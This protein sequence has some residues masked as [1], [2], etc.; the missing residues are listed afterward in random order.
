MRRAAK[1]DNI[2]P[3]TVAALRAVGCT[4]EPIHTIGKGCPDLLVGVRGL[5]LL[6][7]LKSGNEPLTEAEREWH[8]LWRGQRIVVRSVDEALAAVSAAVQGTAQA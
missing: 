1:V 5:N 8:A 2:Q 7:E 4:V 3:E 6:L